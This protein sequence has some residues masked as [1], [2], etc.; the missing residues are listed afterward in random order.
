M[1]VKEIITDYDI[2]IN[3]AIEE[4]IPDAE[5]LGCFFSAKFV[6]RSLLISVLQKDIRKVFIKLNLYVLSML[7]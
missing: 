4:M 7:T 6:R 3:K 2:N 5:I 1:N